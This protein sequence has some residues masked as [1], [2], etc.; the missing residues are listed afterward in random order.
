MGNDKLGF[1]ELKHANC[2]QQQSII[3]SGFILKDFFLL[4]EKGTGGEQVPLSPLQHSW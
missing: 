2:L 4:L 1:K 3:K